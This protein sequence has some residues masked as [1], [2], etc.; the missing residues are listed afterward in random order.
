MADFIGN[1]PFGQ[2]DAQGRVIPASFTAQSFRGD[3]TGTNL[4]YEGYARPGSA[5]SAAVWQIRKHAY[6]GSNNRTSTLWPQN[7]AGLANTDYQFIWDNRASL[8]YS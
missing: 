3:S 1:R 8:T 5:T 4:I 7:T 6:D 2:L